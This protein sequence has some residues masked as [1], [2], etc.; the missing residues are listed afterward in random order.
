MAGVAFLDLL[1]FLQGHQRGRGR[2][3]RRNRP[4]QRE[5]TTIFTPVVPN[6]K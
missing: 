3:I 2:E 6:K 1:V 4:N 5:A